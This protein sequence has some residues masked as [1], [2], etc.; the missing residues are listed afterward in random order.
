MSAHINEA[1]DRLA[2]FPD[3]ARS[4]LPDAAPGRTIGWLKLATWWR[5]CRARAALR[6]ELHQLSPRTL[7]DLGISRADFPAIIAG[8]FTKDGEESDTGWR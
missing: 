6:A 3:A 5:A 7:A 4:D 8:T 2:S 1:I